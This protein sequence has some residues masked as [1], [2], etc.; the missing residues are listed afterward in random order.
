MAH[1]GPKVESCA[2]QSAPEKPATSG[3]GFRVIFRGFTWSGT[4]RIWGSDFR[5]QGLGLSVQ[6]VGIWD[7]GFKV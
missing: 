3:L 1:I 5:F 6:D 2:L 7:L 4:F